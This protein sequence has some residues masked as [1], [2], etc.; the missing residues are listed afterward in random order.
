M[1][2]VSFNVNGIRAI[3]K[4]DFARDVEIM[5][6]DILCLQETKAQDDQV[7]EALEGFKDYHIYSNSAVK[8]GYSGTAILSKE[9]PLAVD[10]DLKIEE[11]DQEGRVTCA[12]YED[13]F[14]VTVYVPNSKNDL[15]RLDY[16]TTWDEALLNYVK[17]L[18]KSKPVIICGDFNV[19][20]KEID[21]ARPKQ[22]YDK[23]AGFTQKEIDGMDAFTS[24]GLV[25]TFRALNPDQV[26]Y[27][28]WS[29]R[30]G[31][32]EKNVGW[33]IDYFLVSESLM[34]RVKKAQILNEIMGSD[35]C[36]VL[37]E[38]EN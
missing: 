15:S 31:A 28:W 9:K 38:L 17:D 18:E 7:A 4:K 20:H 25:D 16:R 29:Y 36:P 13:Y 22:N 26:K 8:K 6:P 33:R 19:A 11:H 1:R 5:N 2:I 35:H 3:L 37:I 14:V 34:P 23:S 24:N 30:G 10:F 21:L 32:R 12:E 27:S